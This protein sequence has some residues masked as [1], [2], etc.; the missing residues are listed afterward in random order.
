MKCEIC[1]KREATVNDECEPCLNNYFDRKFYRCDMPS[2][3]SNRF[4]RL[5]YKLKIPYP[6]IHKV[7]GGLR[8]I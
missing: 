7:Y 2:F 6:I 3:I 8:F 4:V 5:A 1:N